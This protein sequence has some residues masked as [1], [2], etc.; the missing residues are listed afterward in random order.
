[1]YFEK[2]KTKYRQH[3][4]SSFIVPIKMI[5]L[6]FQMLYLKL[7][8]RFEKLWTEKVMNIHE[9]CTLYVFVHNLIIFPIQLA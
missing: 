1:M 2:N 8:M 5:K 6:Q 3:P 7:L 9:N 4:K